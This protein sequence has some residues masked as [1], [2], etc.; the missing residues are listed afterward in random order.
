MNTQPLRKSMLLLFLALALAATACGA[1]D[2]EGTGIVD[3]P[4]G[5]DGDGS[6]G[7]VPPDTG[8]PLGGGPYAVA[9]LS[10][11]VEHPDREP[12]SYELACFGDTATLTPDSIANVSAAAAC[13]ALAEVEIENY[14][15]D[16]PPSDQVCTQIYGGPDTAHLVGRVNDRPVD[17]VVSRAN[18]CG[19]SSW[20]A[21]LADILPPAVGAL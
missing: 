16:G 1:S 13:T 6:D 11:D 18:G 19:I 10:V 5:S 21:L 4:I 2:P 15:V 7:S 17:I 8:L 12:I 9:T 20:D 14:L 3:A